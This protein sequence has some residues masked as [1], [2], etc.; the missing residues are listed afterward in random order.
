MAHNK[1][2]NLYHN[3]THIYIVERNVSQNVLFIISNIILSI[4]IYNTEK[5]SNN[6]KTNIK[7]DGVLGVTDI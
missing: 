6:S 3:S 1:K 5:P 4:F 2:Y 7:N